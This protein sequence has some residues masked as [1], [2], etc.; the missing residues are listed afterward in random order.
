MPYAVELAIDPT[1][2]DEVR[3]AWRELDGA[4]ITWMARSGAWVPHCTL[5]TDLEPHQFGSALA[6]AARV[7]LPLECRL[8][9][10]GIVEFRPVKQLV[11]YGLD[12]SR[13]AGA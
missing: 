8:V 13:R 7:P 10:V 5:A 11:S 2:A 9:E 12:G 6:I 1:S 4:G 3:R